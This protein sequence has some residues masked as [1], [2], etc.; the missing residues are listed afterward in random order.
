MAGERHGWC[1]LVINVLYG[2]LS[3]KALTDWSCVTEVEGVYCA[4]RTEFLYKTNKFL[5]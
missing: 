2:L 5:L 1:E 3:C 4:V